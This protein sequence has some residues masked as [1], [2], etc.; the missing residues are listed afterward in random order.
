MGLTTAHRLAKRGCSIIL[1]E[2]KEDVGYGANYAN[3]AMLVPS[4]SAP[5]NTPGILATLIKSFVA[6]EPAVR[7]RLKAIPSLANWGMH[8]LNNSKPHLY[9][10]NLHRILHLALYSMKV[11]EEY[12]QKYHDQFDARKCGTIKIF[13]DRPRLEAQNKINNNLDEAGLDWQTLTPKEIAE[14]EPHLQ[15]IVP[16]LV[17][18]IRFPADIVADSQKFCR[19]LRDDLIA[20][21]HVVLTGCHAN[22][23]LMS[24]D[25]VVGVRTS[26]GDIRS[27]TTVLALGAKTGQLVPETTRSISVRPVKGYSLTY[28]TTAIKDL[29]ALPVIDEA[30]HVGVVPLTRKLRV[31]GIAEFTGFDSSMNSKIVQQLERFIKRIYPDLDQELEDCECES[32]SGFRAMSAD[33]LPY[34][35]HTSHKGLWVNTGHGHLGWTLA[36]GSA[37]LLADLI[38]GNHPE[39]DPTPYAVFR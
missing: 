7:V 11:F 2:T 4:Q 5:W 10:L 12:Y 21:G 19:I 38:T 3:G 28:D 14:A 9:E 31:V 30:L 16:Q 8:F 36:T 6:Q 13:R 34:I 39:I 18:G 35:G 24:G 22:E 33:G 17:G 20:S 26:M 29:P 37:E 25:K 23:L 15:T 1:V 27:K 32:W